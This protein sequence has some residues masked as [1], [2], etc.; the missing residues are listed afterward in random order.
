MPELQRS[1][2]TFRRSGSSGLVWDDTFFA[3]DRDPKNKDE[4][5]DQEKEDEFREPRPSQSMGF[6]RSGVMPCL[7]SESVPQTACAPSG[8]PPPP[9]RSQSFSRKVFRVIR[10]TMSTKQPKVSRC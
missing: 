4:R 2:A 6:A 3:E 10:K 7:Q 5:E 1:V 8:L 9:P